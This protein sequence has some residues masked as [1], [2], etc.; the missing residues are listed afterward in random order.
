MHKR[1]DI[2]CDDAITRYLSGSSIKQVAI[3]CGCSSTTITRRL[4]DKDITKRP[5][6]RVGVYKEMTTDLEGFIIGMMMGDSSFANA[7]KRKLISTEHSIAQTG[8]LM[9]KFDKLSYIIGGKIYFRDRFDTRT[10]R[11]YHPIAYHS[12]TH[13]AIDK[14]HREFFKTGTKQIT[15]ELLERITPEGIA[16]WYCDDGC[17]YRNPMRYT[18][19]PTI[20]TN[21]FDD[22]SRNLMM[23]MFK[24][25]YGLIFKVNRSNGSIRMCNIT[26]IQKFFALF[27]RFIPACM[28][29]KKASVL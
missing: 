7:R 6:G 20:A 3:S 4:S 21:A 11:T 14:M 13:P 27:G 12:A 18:N 5:S 19:Q 26:G 1:M 22:D 23:G 17:L 8:Y 10:N 15:S 29:Y 16:V 28:E 9:W 24:E 25:K 2:S